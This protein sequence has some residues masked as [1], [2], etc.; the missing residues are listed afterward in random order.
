MYPFSTS[1]VSL[2][3]ASALGVRVTAIPGAF[4]WESCNL[5]DQGCELGGSPH[6]GDAPLGA[7][8]LPDY[9][10]LDL[11][12]R[13]HWHAR[14]LGRDGLLALFATYSN[15]LGRRNLLTYSL[16]PDT[17]ERVGVELRPAAV[18]VLGL[19]WRY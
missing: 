16:D 6:Y 3:G 2:G 19:D 13:Q 4:E 8:R 5:R 1:A 12:V 18:L 14:L 15:L 17:G 11:G 9:A 7:T 10:R